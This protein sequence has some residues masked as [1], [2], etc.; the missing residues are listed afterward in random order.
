MSRKTSTHLLKR[1]SRHF[2]G[3]ETFDVTE[4]STFGMPYGQGRYNLSR[5]A[6]L[7]F[8]TNLNAHDVTDVVWDGERRLSFKSHGENVTITLFLDTTDTDKDTQ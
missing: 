3:P 7:T 6:G 5:F 4:A 8:H 2:S 1:E